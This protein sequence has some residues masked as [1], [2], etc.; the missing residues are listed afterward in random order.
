LIER[1]AVQRHRAIVRRFRARQQPDQRRLA[2]AVLA[3]QRLHFA[4]LHREVDAIQRQHAGIRFTALETA[5][6]GGAG[7]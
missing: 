4:R 7:W 6:M 5:A 3:E 2:G 1:S